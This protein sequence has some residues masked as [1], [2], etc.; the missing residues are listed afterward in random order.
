M[1]A[2]E[3]FKVQTVMKTALAKL[4]SAYKKLFPLE[5]LY[6]R[7][8]EKAKKNQKMKRLVR[9]IKMVLYWM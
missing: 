4:T 6:K 3:R 2:I 9:K 8:P 5:K 1:V 7:T